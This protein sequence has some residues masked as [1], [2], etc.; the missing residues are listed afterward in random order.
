MTDEGRDLLTSFVVKAG[1]S[2]WSAQR[3]LLLAFATSAIREATNGNDVLEHVQ[4]TWG[5]TLTELCCGDQ[6]AAITFSAV[7]R[8]LRVERGRILDFDVAAAGRDGDRRQCAAHGRHLRAARRRSCCRHTWRVRAS[9]RRQFKALRKHVRARRAPRRGPDCRGRAPNL[10]GGDL[11]DLP[12]PRR[13]CRCGAG[14]P[15]AVR[16]AA[17]APGGPAAVDPSHGGHDRG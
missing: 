14:P 3:R 1:T 17:H 2:R 8:W 15:G 5:V 4:S 11:Q 7:R 13:I 9:P 6:E 16:G 10:V 12:L